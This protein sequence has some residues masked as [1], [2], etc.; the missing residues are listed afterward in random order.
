MSAITPHGLAKSLRATAARRATTDTPSAVAAEPNG[1][2]FY[3]YD[4]DGG[5]LK[6]VVTQYK[7]PVR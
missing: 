5:I 1:A 4:N 3:V 6:V 2:G 7:E